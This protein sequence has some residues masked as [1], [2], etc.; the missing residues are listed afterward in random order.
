MPSLVDKKILQ[1]IAKVYQEV[2]RCLTPFSE[3][4]TLLQTIPCINA[5][6]AAII[7][8]EIGAD[9]S[10]FPSAKHLASW[11]GVCPGNR[12]SGGK[13]RET[14]PPRKAMS[15]CVPFWERLPEASL[16]LPEPIC[17]PNTTGSLVDEAS[18]RPSG[19]LHIASS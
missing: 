9:M 6:A 10:R 17:M 14:E 8:A 12:Q 11:A 15:G 18:R 4:V 13:R 5:I 19:L 2:E 7:V 1:A 3:A 16:V